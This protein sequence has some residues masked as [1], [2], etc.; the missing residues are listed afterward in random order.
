MIFDLQNNIINLLKKKTNVK[1]LSN[2][3]KEKKPG[4]TKK[5]NSNNNNILTEG[6]ENI[7]PSFFKNKDIIKRFSV[8]K[9]NNK[10]NIF[11]NKKQIIKS[12]KKIK[13]IKIAIN[14]NNHNLTRKNKDM[15][16]SYYIDSNK[17]IGLKEK[18]E[19]FK[20]SPSF[21]GRTNNTKIKFK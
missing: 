13:N 1:K 17:K 2:I 5:N 19:L 3:E 16:I 12:P 20:K 21:E 9:Q 18:N 14:I 4:L 10:R 15:N 11:I 8:F 7:K 6:N